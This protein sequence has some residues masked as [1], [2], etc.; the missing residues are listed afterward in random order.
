MGLRGRDYVYHPSQIK[1]LGRE[2]GFYF[3]FF[4]SKFC[5]SIYFYNN[6]GCKYS[7]NNLFPNI[8]HKTMYC[9]AIDMSVKTLVM[10]TF[11]NKLLSSCAVRSTTRKKISL[12]NYIIFSSTEVAYRYSSGIELWSIDPE[13]YST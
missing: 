6:S 10:F 11:G 2:G 1:K 4:N 13:L 7:C 5:I 12:L 9:M 3:Y 8:Y